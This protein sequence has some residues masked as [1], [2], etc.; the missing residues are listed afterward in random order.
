MDGGLQLSSVRTALDNFEG[1]KAIQRKLLTPLL[2]H[3]Q[4]D[5]D[6]FNVV[7][8]N[9]QK[10]IKRIKDNV[11]QNLASGEPIDLE[12]IQSD[13][14]RAESDMHEKKADLLQRFNAK[15]DTI[16]A[17]CVLN[18]FNVFQQGE[19]V[20]SQTD[21]TD[22]RPDKD[23]EIIPDSRLHDIE[24]LKNIINP[25][26]NSDR[27]NSS[28]CHIRNDRIMKSPGTKSHT[29]PI[30]GSTISRNKPST[31]SIPI[32]ADARKGILAMIQKKMIPA[33]ASLI[34]MS[35]PIKMKKA[36]L[37]RPSEKFLSK[38][39]ERYNFALVRFDDSCLSAAMPRN[40]PP[41][42]TDMK[43]A[44]SFG[45]HDG[46]SREQMIKAISSNRIEVECD[47][48][49]LQLQNVLLSTPEVPAFNK[50]LKIQDGRTV[51]DCPDFQCFK[52]S[53]STSWLVIENLL[54]Q[55]ETLMRDYSV[56]TAFVDGQRLVDMSLYFELGPPP[57]M[58]DLL[59]CVNNSEQVEKIIL[60]P[61]R[62]YLAPD[63][64][65]MAATLIQKRW[66]GFYQS[67]LYQ[68][69]KR[70][71]MVAGIK[72]VKWIMNIKM[73]LCKKH[74][75]LKN[76]EYLKNYHTRMKMMREKWSTIKTSRR[77]VVHIPSLGYSKELRSNLNDISSR[78]NFQ[79]GRICDIRDPKVDVIYISPTKMDQE[80]EE[81]YR[82]ILRTMCLAS[83]EDFD[84]VSAR[85]TI[86]TPESI[87]SFPHNLCLSSIMKYSDN[88]VQKVQQM[89]KGRY[90]HFFLQEQT[91][92][93]IKTSRI[94]DVEN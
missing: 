70:R 47:M 21:I 6:D 82:G 61:G 23:H 92:L 40:I 37:H 66:R 30:T 7:L 51:R 1:D 52:Q 5:D 76:Q 63:G 84:E 12:R 10:E 20:S 62:R 54:S 19:L 2:R 8:E 29:K 74:L 80:M 9:A 45:K 50:P 22:E 89:T 72:A 90:I 25:T 18:D 14:E 33:S 71:K 73:T 28:R 48:S 34:M 4:D 27:P 41:N 77:V 39:D 31:Q 65:A 75:V 42:S 58:K 79:M 49:S 3:T 88:V 67:C 59:L 86:L 56:P 17:S 13:F 85:L 38:Q 55:V 69:G 91:I 64:P 16:S 43:T 68:E 87:G 78:Q 36:I 57:T 94:K 35:S 60:I 44:A 24:R 15:A 26:Q 83:G 81:Y 11:L 32:S 93:F 53:H 46:M